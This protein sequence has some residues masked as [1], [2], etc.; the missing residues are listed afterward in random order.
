MSTIRVGPDVF[1]A[2]CDMID[3][4]SN[5]RPDTSWRHVDPSGHEHRWFANGVPAESYNQAAAHDVPS[6]VWV[7]TDVGYYED[8]SEYEIGHNECRECGAHVEPRY[9][10]DMWQ[11]MMPG[12]HWFKINGQSVTQEDFAARVDVVKAKQ[13]TKTK[14]ISFDRLLSLGQCPVKCADGAFGLAI[15]WYQDENGIG[16]QVPGEDGIRWISVGR[17]IEDGNGALSER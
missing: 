4:T 10:A 11:Q 7:K 16:V 2:G 17:I 1:E 12:R 3:V 6:L 14:P 9:T 13:A 15:R 5:N 8:G